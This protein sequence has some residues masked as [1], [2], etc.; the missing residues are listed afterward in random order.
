MNSE[1]LTYGLAAIA[2]V[3]VVGFAVVYLGRFLSWIERSEI[4]RQEADAAAERKKK[5]AS[6]RAAAESE[7][8]GVSVHHIA[9]IAA[10][11]AACGYRV[12]HIAAQ[13]TGHAWAYEG[14]RMHQTSH[15]MPHHVSHRAQ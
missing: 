3:V 6:G 12:V 1:T 14:R 9:A 5:S 13:P 2:A 8:E 11:V 15:R 4:A 10:A 7:L